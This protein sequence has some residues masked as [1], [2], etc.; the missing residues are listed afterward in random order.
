MSLGSYFQALICGNTSFVRYRLKRIDGSTT[1]W[2]TQYAIVF[3]EKTTFLLRKPIEAGEAC[4]LVKASG[5]HCDFMQTC[6]CQ[7]L[8]AVRLRRCLRAVLEEL[9]ALVTEAPPN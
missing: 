8:V 2:T 6:T 1:K 9:Y 4:I 7:C 5:T 3:I